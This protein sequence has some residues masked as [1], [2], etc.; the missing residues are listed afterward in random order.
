MD[1]NNGTSHHKMMMKDFKK[2][3]K[4]SAILTIPVL[5]LSPM[6]QEW[7]GLDISFK[8]D[9]YILFAI[10]TAIYFYGGW[11]FLKGL[12]KEVKDKSPGMMTLIGLAISVAYI[13]SSAVVF[14]LEGKFFFWEL[15]TLID[16]MLLGHWLEMRSIIGASSALEKLSR[17]LPDNAHL[18]TDEGT[19]DVKISN[20]SKGDKIQIKPG[21][22]IPAD[23][24]IFEGESYV[25]ESM[26]TGESEPVD[27]EKGNGVVGGS[28]NGDGPIRVKITQTGDESYLNKM[29]NLV[30]EA[31]KSKSK[32]ERFA[33]T[34][35]KWLTF[36][37]IT[38]GTITLFTWLGLE[39]DFTFSLERM[40]SVMVITCPHA[41]G[42]AIPLVVAVST[43]LAAKNGLLIR[44]RT[45]FENARKIDTVIF[46]KTGTLTEGNFSVTGIEIF[47][48]EYDKNTI[49]RLAASLE[50]DSEHPIGKS[51][52]SRAKEEEIELKEP[53]EFNYLK[54]KG[55]EGTVEGKK[56]LL[57]GENFLKEKN[58]ETP[59]HR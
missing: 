41:L 30:R 4:I 8:S 12:Y 59:G 27:K 52:I 43:A 29:M 14:G 58:Y 28:I 55:I 48:E 34:A 40:V 9:R 7:T 51:I 26:L 21:E 25:D 53:E 24:E 3:F 5:V 57:G 46:D 10:S 45:P 38:V 16:V 15:A 19:E 11:P 54:G 22:K 47:N 42:L 36:T 2:R 32:T 33:D 56:V 23:G 1:Q 20:L 17:L 50:Q 35:A 44:N 37:S 13:Y 6:V 39:K 31:Q 49:L 18:I